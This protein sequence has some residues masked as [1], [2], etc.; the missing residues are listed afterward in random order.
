[1]DGTGEHSQK[2]KCVKTGKEGGKLSLSQV[3][4][5]L[6]GKSKRSNWKIIWRNGKCQEV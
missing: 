3:Y 5:S 4:D 1:M 2:G 6:P